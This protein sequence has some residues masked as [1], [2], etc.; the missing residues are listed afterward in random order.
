MD[1]ILFLQFPNYDNCTPLYPNSS[2][3]SSSVLKFIFLRI[4][5]DS[6]FPIASIPCYQR[7]HLFIHPSLI[8]LNCHELCR[9]PG[10]KAIDPPYAQWLS[11]VRLSA[12]PWTAAHRAPL[13]IEFPRQEYWSGLPCSPPGYPPDPEIE[14]MS[15][16]VSGRFFT[17]STCWE[18]LQTHFRGPESPL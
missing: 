5:A 8:M 10:N 16:V 1:V 11:C 7:N 14:P 3:I 9:S 4:P 2:L 6:P 13:S 12:N 15:P 17:T 18:A